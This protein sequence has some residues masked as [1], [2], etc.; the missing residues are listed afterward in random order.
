MTT[1]RQIL[2]NRRNGA[3]SRGPKTAAGKA[4]SSRNALRHGLAAPLG[5]DPDRHARIEALATLLASSVG[6]AAP[7]NARIGA[8]AELELERVRAARR[9]LMSQLL[10]TPDRSAEVTSRLLRL[11]RYERRALAK[12]NRFFEAINPRASD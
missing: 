7:A 8:E 10:G 6:S 12:R 1:H 2:A 9:D 3:L 4:R 5:G 11:E